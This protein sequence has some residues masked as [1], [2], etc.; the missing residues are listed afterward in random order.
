MSGRR[1]Q[2]ATGTIDAKAV[3]RVLREIVWPDLKRLGFSRRTPRTAWRDR[4]GAVQV[5]NFQSFNSYLAE[6]IGSTT[7]SF[8]VNLGVFYPAIAEQ[9]PVAAFIPDWSRPPEWHC[10][11]RKHLGK[12]I[13]QPNEPAARRWF[14]PRA[15]QP[16]LGSWVDRPD[17]WYV[18][19]D[20]SNL[21]IVVNDAHD[22]ITEIGLPWLDRLSDLGEARRRF[23]TVESTELAPGIGDEDYG[24]AIG[25]PNR[26]Y[27]VGALSAALRDETGLRSAV[28][29]MTAHPYFQDRP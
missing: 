19:G 23:E 22:R 10:Q 14:D 16:S 24:G 20:G 1:A 9:T 4:P 15:P 8:G 27:A 6:A 17:V 13:V 11:A 5:V 26:W 3:N 18:L 21:D 7:F 25:S 2:A 29:A 28:D 12:G